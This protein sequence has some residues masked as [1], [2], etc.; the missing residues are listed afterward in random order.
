MTHEN[1]DL[2]FMKRL[3]TFIVDKRNFFFLFYIF[4]LVFSLFSTGWVNVENDI[5]TYLGEETETR[6]GLEVMNGEFASFGSA[7]IMVSGVTYD[8]AKALADE[9]S[10]L[11][12]VA[13][14][15]FDDTDSHYT[16]ASALLDITFSGSDNAPESVAA[17]AAI[18]EILMPYDTYIDSFVGYDAIADLAFEM[19]EIIIVAAVII[20]IVLVLT[21]TAYMEVPVLLMTFG[22]AA[23]LNMGTN[24]LCGTISFISN[25][26][27]VV[28]QLALAI[29]YAIILCHRFSFEHEDKPAR[30]ACIEALSKAIPEISSSSL[31]TVSGLAAL[32]F[33]HFGIGLDL[34]IVMIKAIFLSLLSVFTLMPGLLMLFS[35]LIDKTKHRNLVPPI[36]AIGKF[37]LKTRFIV[38]PL[39][40]AVTVGAFFL[41]GKCPYAY[42]YNDVT[43]AKQTQQQMAATKIKQTFGASNMLAL[44][45]PTGDY[46]SERMMLAEFE[47][48]EGVTGT[49][50]LSGI[51]AS[52]GYSLTDAL[53]PR[54]FS[55]LIGI[56]YEA[57][58]LLYSAYAAYDSQY[59]QLLTGVG[60]YR[61]PLFDMFCFLKDRM[62][63]GNIHLDDADM[64]D[65]L[66][67]L[68][69]AK[70]Q[71]RTENFSRMVIYM[72]LP[73][74]GE[75]TY[76]V[77]RTLHDIADKYY[78]EYYFVGNTTS[79]MDLSASFTRDNLLI[80]VL[81]AV[82]VIVI[83]LLTFR[84]VGLPILLI[85]VIQGS[86]W[87]NFSIP[88][89]THTPL[90][91]L[92]YLIVNAIQ[93][94]ANIDY[95]IVISSHYSDLKKRMEPKAAIVQALNESFA[96]VFT[97]GG[98]M[99]SA[100][101]LISVLTANPVIAT[102]GNCL[103]RGTIISIVLVLCVL[104]QILLMGDAL[105]ERTTF[106]SNRS[107]PKVQRRDG[108]MVVHGHVKGYVNGFVDAQVDGLLRGELDAQVTLDSVRE[109]DDG[110]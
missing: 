8:T 49:M 82:F 105:V 89:I 109:G 93:M 54:Q 73:E 56:D 61:V 28:L 18:R 99:V 51:E 3:A 66:S 25:S 106:R 6:R 71:L 47:A 1:R 83:L 59:G 7:R 88:A 90:Y 58:R 107:A 5:T 15:S 74:E 65:M 23:V 10:A 27:T 110:Q 86:I 24:F 41:S 55:E 37:D 76:G 42:G 16:A 97:S 29:D 102:M 96:T 77:V 69:S 78:D 33:M 26:V 100:G 34:A 87:I 14:L 50:G 75:R 31:T 12:G 35:P 68:D 94:G 44:I 108:Q 9:I 98:I 103:G 46:E 101:M 17:M 4:A 30:I 39:F 13:M 20:V 79:C 60:S 48:V 43:T 95:A 70:S 2:S 80:S 91:F 38:P 64:E 67:Q 22:A 104:P 63:T 32:G 45:V 19:L 11:D 21:S 53:T 57:S 84:S 81:S 62:D 92:G 40:L 52:D 85:L 36:T 72:D